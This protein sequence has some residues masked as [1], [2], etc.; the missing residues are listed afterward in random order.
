M[1][2]KRIE[3]KHNHTLTQ[4]KRKLYKDYGYLWHFTIEEQMD[5][6]PSVIAKFAYQVYESKNPWC[7]S[8]ITCQRPSVPSSE[9]MVAQACC[10][11]RA[12]CTPSA[13]ISGG[14]FQRLLKRASHS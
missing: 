10:Q 9:S 2:K 8:S 5:Y 6:G 1:I 3:I 13:S 14:T 11:I 12:T 7:T 4:L